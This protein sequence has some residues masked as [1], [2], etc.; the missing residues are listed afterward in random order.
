MT[1]NS[2]GNWIDGGDGNDVLMAADQATIT[3]IGGLGDD[4]YYVATD[5]S[6]NDDIGG[7]NDL[8]IAIAEGSYTL[9]RRN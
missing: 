4:T 1:G 8:L 6:V 3:L 9:A 2:G 5:D 7:A